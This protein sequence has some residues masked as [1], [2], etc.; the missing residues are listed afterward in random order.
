MNNEFD[1]HDDHEEIP[2]KDSGLDP[3]RFA[4]WIIFFGLCIILYGV[5]WLLCEK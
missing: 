4:D 5:W 3:A 1:Y 2:S